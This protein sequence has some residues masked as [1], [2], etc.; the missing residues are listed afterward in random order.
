MF[1]DLG[2]ESCTNTGRESHTI[3]MLR[4]PSGLTVDALYDGAK[5]RGFIIYRAKGEFADRYI[6]IANMGELSDGTI[7]V[8][9]A[10]IAD[11]VRAARRT[12]APAA[13][14]ALKSV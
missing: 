14:P 8:F 5:A 1:A 2:F 13:R 9:L 3:S 12:D 6:Q 4:L 10:A 7:D 11:V